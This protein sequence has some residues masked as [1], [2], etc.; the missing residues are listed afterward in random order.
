M[1]SIEPFEDETALEFVERAET[2]EASDDLIRTILSSNFQIG[3]DAAQKKLRLMSRVFWE[4]FFR[5]HV[6]SIFD[7]GG[8]RYSALIYIQKKNGLCGQKKLTD[9]Q[10]AEL[11]DSVGNWQR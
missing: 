2:M 3:D 11:V 8:S 10:I 9:Q 6:Q 4:R 1:T 7:R 5:T